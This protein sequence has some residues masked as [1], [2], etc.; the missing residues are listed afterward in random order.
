[1]KLKNKPPRWALIIDALEV[2][3]IKAPLYC[4]A[5][6]ITM[7]AIIYIVPVKYIPTNDQITSYMPAPFQSDFFLNTPLPHLL[8][9]E[10]LGIA[11]V[12]Y[13][14]Q[15]VGLGFQ[16]DKA[17][18]KR[19][20]RCRKTWRRYDHRLSDRK[21][22]LKEIRA[23]RS[24]LLYVVRLLIASLK[25]IKPAISEEIKPT[26][27]EGIKPA[28]LEEIKAGKEKEEEI[29]KTNAHYLLHSMPL[30]EVAVFA[31]Q[32]RERSG[33][34][35]WH[36]DVVESYRELWEEDETFKEKSINGRLRLAAAR[37]G[38]NKVSPTILKSIYYAYPDYFFAKKMREIL[39]LTK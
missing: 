19:Y 30:E 3:A 26:I 32:Y 18:S 38:R 8:F 5:F 12:V 13:A 29:N 4:V 7:M 6:T 28:I 23:R 24:E 33:K 22:R 35:Y 31:S 34:C 36:A 25:E 10:I 9:I 39:K 16:W 15:K 20:A 17:I 27:L 2:A 21:Q 11:A 37:G 1:M 14:L